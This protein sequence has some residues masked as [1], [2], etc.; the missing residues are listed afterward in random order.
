MSGALVTDTHPLV[1]W[2]G[3]R[4]K[5]S[6]RARRAFEACTEGRG[7]IYVP[8]AVLL[9]MAL[10]EEAGK[11]RL[12][13]SFPAWVDDLF[14]S[15][16]FVPVAVEPVHV[17]D[18]WAMRRLSDPFDRL[19]VAAAKQSDLPLISRDAD[20]ARSRLVELLW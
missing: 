3:P 14:T 18:A 20:I 13:I 9:E 11:I 4:Q 15:P 12:K 8:A 6:T 2:A 7:L 19:I 17:K 1:W 5:L 10:L 16:G